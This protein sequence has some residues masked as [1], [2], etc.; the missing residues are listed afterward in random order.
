MLLVKYIWALAWGK[1]SRKS[2]LSI[3]SIEVAHSPFPGCSRE[4]FP[5]S[6]AQSNYFSS[7][8]QAR[9]KANFINIV[10]IVWQNA[11]LHYRDLYALKPLTLELWILKFSTRMVVAAGKASFQLITAFDKCINPVL[12]TLAISR[13]SAGR[14]GHSTLISWYNNNDLNRFEL[15]ISICIGLSRVSTLSSLWNIKVLH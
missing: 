9:Y 4:G 13:T 2:N 14:G 8:Y 6:S 10:T 1:T 5:N 12:P 7:R 15:A 11:I 3:H